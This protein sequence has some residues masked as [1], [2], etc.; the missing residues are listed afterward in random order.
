MGINFDK[1]YE[2]NFNDGDE[3]ILKLE[4]GLNENIIKQISNIKKEPDWLLKSRINAYKIFSNK[5]NPD[6]GPNLS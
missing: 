4:N 2:F 3:N 6:W 5:L 1:K